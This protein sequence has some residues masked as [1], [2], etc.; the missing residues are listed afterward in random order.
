[1]AYEE[2]LLEVKTIKERNVFL[3]LSDADCDR[4]FN[5]CGEYGLTINELIESFIGDLVDGTYTSGSDERRYAQEWF[6]R[7]FAF[8]FQ[9]TLLSHL[10]A[11]GVEPET[12][13]SRLEWIEEAEREKRALALRE[14]RSEET[15]E[16]IADWDENIGIWEE[17]IAEL[18][19]GWTPEEKPD[20]ETERER[21]QNWITEKEKFKRPVKVARKKTCKCK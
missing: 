21:I 11:I 20:M 8:D 2:T 6:E 3:N 19:E 13:I 15:D 5:Q 4:L 14:D 17:E 18:L 7:C 10:I 9:K 16:E 1:M 12:Y